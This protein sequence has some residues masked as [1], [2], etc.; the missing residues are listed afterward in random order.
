MRRRRHRHSRRARE[1]KRITRLIG[2]HGLRSLPWHAIFAR[3]LRD[4]TASPEIV[5]AA[6]VAREQW[7]RANVPPVAPAR[8]VLTP[9]TP[10]DGVAPDTPAP[11]QAF[12]DSLQARS[13]RRTK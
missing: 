8:A 11:G 3:Q 4:G 6:R 13:F 10:R 2:P 1:I 5:E 9:S 12:R 7:E